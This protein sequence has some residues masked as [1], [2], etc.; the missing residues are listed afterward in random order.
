LHRCGE[1]VVE[2]QVGLGTE[3]WLQN[4]QWEYVRMQPAD[5]F[6]GSG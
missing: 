6:A 5:Y 2:V 1:D 3:P 4:R